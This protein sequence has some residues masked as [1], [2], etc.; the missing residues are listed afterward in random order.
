MYVGFF[1]RA[2]GEGPQLGTIP[3]P[4]R[5]CLHLFFLCLGMV[6]YVYT[7]LHRTAKL[8][9][10]LIQ[11]LLATEVT[12]HGYSAAMFLLCMLFPLTLFVLLQRAL[13][14]DLYLEGRRTTKVT[15]KNL[16]KYFQQVKAVDG[17]NLEVSAG[18]F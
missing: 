13:L 18:N 8:M 4:Y 1:L 2:F 17:L 9:S 11:S 15:L 10:I 12:D 6:L 3:D 14:K 5:R 7:L 16:C